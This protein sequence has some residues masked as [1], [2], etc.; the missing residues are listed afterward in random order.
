VVGG[1]FADGD[2]GGV[3]ASVCI[4]LDVPRGSV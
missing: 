1:G 4:V 3:G 2:G